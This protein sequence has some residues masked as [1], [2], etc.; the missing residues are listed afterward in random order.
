MKGKKSNIKFSGWGLTTTLSTPWLGC[1][2]NKTYIGFNNAKKILDNKIK[3]K[4]FTLQQAK[5][6]WLN[7]AENK[8]NNFRFHHISTDEV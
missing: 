7:L 1:S 4:E 5:N 3:N 2:K 8:K 6:Y